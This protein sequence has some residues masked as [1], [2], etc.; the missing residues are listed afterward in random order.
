MPP[1]AKARARGKA[2]AQAKAR[3]VALS[4]SNARRDRREGAVREL[5]AL[6]A[7]VN[8]SDAALAPKTATGTV[9]ERLV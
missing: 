1:R 3:A 7:E 5:N 8:V 9:F 6:A 4:R 2:K